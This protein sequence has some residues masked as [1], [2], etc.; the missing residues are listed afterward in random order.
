MPHLYI[1]PTDSAIE[2]RAHL[3]E[4]DPSQRRGGGGG[5]RAQAQRN[6]NLPDPSRLHD[7]PR[8]GYLAQMSTT[9]T[10]ELTGDQALVLFDW[11]VRFNNRESEAF[12]DQAE[13]RVLW[14]IEARLESALVEP[15][16][17][18]YARLLSEARER[19]RDPAM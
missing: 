12:E 2:K 14:D 8:H 4:A 16:D 10:L 6:R 1:S 15:F 18:S 19:V 7:L 5:A 3:A 11:I 17:S 9:V 13:Q